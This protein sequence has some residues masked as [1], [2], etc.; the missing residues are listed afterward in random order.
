MFDFDFFSLFF[1]KLC[2]NLGNMRVV[3]LHF[4]FAHAFSH[5]AVTLFPF[6]WFCSGT[7]SI[8]NV[9]DKTHQA[10]ETEKK[11]KQKR[12]KFAIFPYKIHHR[13]S[14]MDYHFLFI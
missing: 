1:E 6:I 10:K 13:G 11:S 14:R 5:I 7:G 8:E 4:W 12:K 3:G 9:K 2:F